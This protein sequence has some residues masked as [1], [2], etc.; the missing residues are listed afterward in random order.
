MRARRREFRTGFARLIAVIALLL[1]L[2]GG[3]AAWVYFG[4]NGENDGEKPVLDVVT[5]GPFEA[6]VL[7]QGEIQS[8][9]NKEIRCE[10]RSRSNS[11][12]TILWV[13]EEGKMV[14]GAII[15]WER[16]PFGFGFLAPVH[17]GFVMALRPEPVLAA[18]G[19]SRAEPAADPSSDPKWEVPPWW[20]GELL[21]ELDSSA[22]KQEFE[23][24][25]VVVNTSE[26]RVITADSN[27]EA[28]KITREEYMLGIFR[29]DEQTILN[30]EF[31]AEENLRKA[32]QHLKFSERLAAKSYITS[33]ELRAD[34]FSVMKA[35]NALDLAQRKLAV[36]RNQTKR[37]NLIAFDAE[38]RAAQVISENELK[39]HQV[40][41][42]KLAEIRQQIH[43]CTIRV[44]PMV[45]GQVVHAN[46]FS[47]RGSAEF[48]VE[49]GQAVRE[50]QVLIRLPDPDRMQVKTKVNESSIASVHVGMPAVIQVDALHD[51]DLEGEVE[52]VNQYAE[53]DGF[54]GGGIR[55]YAVYVRITNPPREIRPGMNASVNI[56]VDH[57]NN[58][59]Q[60]PLRAIY[61]LKDQTF[62]LVKK[63]DGWETRE[64]K[65]GTNN[66]RV[67]LIK[68]GVKAGEQV[69]L[70]PR[71]HLKKM[72]LP[73]IDDSTTAKLGDQ[74]QSLP[75]GPKDG[76]KPKSERSNPQGKRG[77]PDP[78]QFDT[79]KDKKLSA[80]ERA[81]MP[82]WMRDMLIKA[83]A[84]N[85]DIVTE[86]EVAKAMAEWKKSR[87]EGGGGGMGGNRP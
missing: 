51:Q 66:A 43:K 60:I 47:S 13:I 49:Q 62:C 34:Q 26:A 81:E 10:V 9:S 7:D 20:R 77:P 72:D 8:S 14:E 64:I 57:R 80:K 79:N 3:G 61:A 36:L 17:A 50:K 71:D 83:D 18:E 75:E 44:P 84:N 58:A 22:L 21:V 40:E 24:Q 65:L 28:A 52:R 63:D 35:K 41:L 55:K 2:V 48:V 67:A 19:K 33:L 78:F 46:K 82:D 29:Q 6:T 76:E 4:G 56:R 53:P 69:V 11:G 85:D 59:V 25:Q 42:N 15:D 5:Q 32:E 27:L 31:E 54:G 1:V 86:A 87:G 68:S 23:D 16:D 39:S 73:E 38:I 74:A 37:K 12:T 45:S 30:E 70:S